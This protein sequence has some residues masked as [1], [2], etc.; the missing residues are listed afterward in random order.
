MKRTNPQE[1]TEANLSIQQ[2]QTAISKLDRRIDELKQFDVGTIHER[3]DPS[4]GALEQK[5]VTLLASIFGI[6]SVE[7]QRYE[8]DV[9][10]LDRA[11]HNAMYEIP[12]D[13][14]KQGIRKGIGTALTCLE[15]IKQGFEEELQD[16]GENSSLRTLKAFEGLELHPE[17][18]RATSRLYKDGHY[19]NA[20]EDSVKALNALVR[21]RSG[22]DDKDG[23]QLMELVF[24]P[25]KPVL[26]FNNLIDVSDKDEQRG[27]MMMFSGAVAGLRNPRAH[28]IIEDDPEMAL[29]FIA[30]VSL[31]AKLLD[32]ATKSD[33]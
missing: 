9:I 28:K 19:D 29:E 18:S 6:K 10:R 25:N 33:S 16:I 12:L 27:F 20:I 30:Y 7:Y 21:L 4:L 26:K 5:M 3:Y 2:M 1:F 17:I 8:P 13:E 22:I 23:S 14:V 31:L 15:T 11:R 24:S 32:R